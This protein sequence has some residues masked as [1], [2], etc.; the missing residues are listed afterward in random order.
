MILPDMTSEQMLKVMNGDKAAIQQFADTYMY[1]EGTRILRSRHTVF[2]CSIAKYMIAPESHQRYLIIFRL[3]TRKEAFDGIRHF[4]HRAII[5]TS[6]GTEATNIMFD[7]QTNR[8]SVVYFRAHLFQRYAERMGLKMPADDVIRYFTKRNPMMI[9]ATEWRK[10]NDCMMM[11]HDGACFGEVND[12]D[13]GLIN[14]KTFISNETMKDDT[15]RSHLNSTYN[16]ALCNAFWE[17][18]FHDPEM[19]DFMMK[20]TNP[21]KIKQT[22]KNKRI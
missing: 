6:Y 10:E 3:A 12:D 9:E 19:S 8:Q 21:R 2:P 14:L 18:Y 11:C 20:T 4:Y 13:T 1:N 15:R 16:D 7:R 17:V 5:N 22:T